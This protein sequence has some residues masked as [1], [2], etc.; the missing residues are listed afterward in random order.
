MALLFFGRKDARSLVL[1]KPRQHRLRPH[2][3]GRHHQLVAQQEAIDVAVVPV[4]LP[5]PWLV[6]GGLAEYADPIVEL[7]EF[8]GQLGEF[9]QMLIESHGVAGSLIRARTDARAQNV[10]REFALQ[11]AQ[12]GETKPVTHQ[13]AMDIAPGPPHLVVDVEADRFTLYWIE[14]RQEHLSGIDHWLN[15]CAGIAWLKQPA[16][17]FTG[18]GHAFEAAIYHKMGQQELAD[19]REGVKYLLSLGFADP[20]RVG[21]QGWSYGGF[22]TLNAMLNAGDMFKAGISG[23][24]VTNFKFYDTIYT[25]RYMGL[26]SEN[27]DGYAGTNLP[28]KAGNLKGKLL[29]VDNFE[30]DNVLFQNMLNATAALQRADKP[31]ELM[32]YPQKSHGVGGAYRAHL[33]ELMTSFFDR[34]LGPGAK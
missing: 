8:L 28:L 16:F 14:R 5:A 15:R 34:T 1:S 17:D 33:S 10:I 27:P 24:P 11:L 6:R 21:I 30:D 18:R 7:A 3:G 12:F 32:I 23:A 25:E 31:F 9:G 2:E 4:E 13:I 26:P 19:Q 29:L 20:D 22:M